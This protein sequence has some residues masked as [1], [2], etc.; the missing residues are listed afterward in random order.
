M[1]VCIYSVCAVLY[2]G[3]GLA[4][5]RSPA[6]GVLP[7]VNRITKLKKKGQGPTKGCRAINEWMLLLL[8]PLYHYIP[9]YHIPL[10]LGPEILSRMNVVTYSE[11]THDTSQKPPVNIMNHA[12]SQQS[13]RSTETPLL[14]L[15]T[16]LRTES[17]EFLE[18]LRW[19][20]RLMNHI[21]WINECTLQQV[22]ISRNAALKR[23]EIHQ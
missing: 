10:I 1:S 8:L 19:V 11:D 20:F 7:T 3:I 17:G 4:T 22:C 6:Q 5:G 9:T 12:P 15:L 23:E 2:A 21:N 16:Y 14:H 13:S 18:L